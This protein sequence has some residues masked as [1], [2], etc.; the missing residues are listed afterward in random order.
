MSRKRCALVMKPYEKNR[1]CWLVST[2]LLQYSDRPDDE[3][4][5][6]PRTK[7]YQVHSRHVTCSRAPRRF[8][9][10]RAPAISHPLAHI[11]FLYR[12]PWALDI[13]LPYPYHYIFFIISE[14]RARSTYHIFVR[15]RSRASRLVL[16]GYPTNFR[17]FIFHFIVQTVL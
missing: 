8:D 14:N 9:T 4:A 5:P 10:R 13:H 15:P 2:L 3:H 11:F 12:S 6:A 7:F 17:C 16:S 1:P